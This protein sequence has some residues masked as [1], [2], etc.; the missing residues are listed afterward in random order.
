MRTYVGR[1]PAGDV[2]RTTDVGEAGEAALSGVLGQQAI[3]A[4]R[5]GDNSIGAASIIVAGIV[6]DGDGRGHGDH[7][8]ERS[9]DGGELHCGG[10]CL[11]EVVVL[12]V[13]EGYR[14]IECLVGCECW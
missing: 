3:G 11:E 7:G 1:V 13:I 14:W 2:F 5:A 6:R 12:R 4:V 8:G 9:E 10:G